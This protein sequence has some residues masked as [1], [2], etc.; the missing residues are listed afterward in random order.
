M[1]LGSW[2]H[3]RLI[4]TSVGP[5]VMSGELS[6]G[7]SHFLQ[8]HFKIKSSLLLLGSLFTISSW[9]QNFFSSLQRKERPASFL[10][11]HIPYLISSPLSPL[12]LQSLPLFLFLSLPKNRKKHCHILRLGSQITKPVFKSFLTLHLY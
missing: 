4:S 3:Y 1:Q 2:F 10:S 7:P 12:H 5:S 11:L 8:E 9:D 6:E